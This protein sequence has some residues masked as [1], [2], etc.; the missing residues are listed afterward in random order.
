MLKLL[1]P[2]EMCFISIYFIKVI[3]FQSHIST[4][5][6]QISDTFIFLHFGILEK[7]WPYL[8]DNI[9]KRCYQNK[10]T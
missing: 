4:T 2:L 6:T 7:E 1:L 10:T 9:W 3:I 5:T 8:L